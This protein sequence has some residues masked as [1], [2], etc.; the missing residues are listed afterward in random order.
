[1]QP[2]IHSPTEHSSVLPRR[3]VFSERLQS[4]HTTLPKGS[5]R[6]ANT[7][8]W[9]PLNSLFQETLQM[10]KTAMILEAEFPSALKASTI[11]PAV[12]TLALQSRR[13]MKGSPTGPD[14]HC[15]RPG[16]RDL[17]GLCGHWAV[18]T[19]PEV[20]ALLAHTLLWDFF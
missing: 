2:F 10:T 4:K 13:S 19:T 8:K 1:M 15:S 5:V 7:R 9:C 11:H 6:E 14:P 17:D 12:L 3:S 16:L 18:G 20:S